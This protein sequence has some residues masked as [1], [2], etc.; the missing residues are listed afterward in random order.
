[1]NRLNVLWWGSPRNTA[2]LRR[3]VELSDTVVEERDR[4]HFCRRHRLCVREIFDGEVCL[5]S[6]KQ[7]D[8]VTEQLDDSNKSESRE[9]GT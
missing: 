1:V 9:T 7:F 2:E 3:L 6:W 8:R 4:I 5:R